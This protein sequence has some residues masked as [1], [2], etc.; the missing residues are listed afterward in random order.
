MRR[1]Y[2][3]QNTTVSHSIRVLPHP[4]AEMRDTLA[5]LPIV[6]PATLCALAA[7]DPPLP[8]GD[9]G[10]DGLEIVGTY[11]DA[12][13]TS[14]EISDSAWIQTFPGYEPMSFDISAW[15]NAERWVVAR[16]GEDN[17]YDAGMWSR[18]DWSAGSDG[19]LYYCQS[20]F[21]AESEQGATDAPAAGEDLD[22][23]C[24]GFSWTD[25]TP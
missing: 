10:A 20:V 4:G 2:S 12:F 5:P 16:N 6:L 19:H 7:C 1:S 8:P 9:T 24:G 13:G 18:F 3:D 15:D 17:A 14:H 25:L 22:A 11:T 23:G 21:S